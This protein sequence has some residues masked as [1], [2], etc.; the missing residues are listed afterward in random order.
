MRHHHYHCERNP[1][2]FLRLKQENVERE[3]REE[4]QR[5]ANSLKRGRV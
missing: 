4:I 2:G 3:S 5:E 1:E